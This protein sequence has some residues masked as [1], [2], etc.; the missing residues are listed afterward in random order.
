MV[1]NERAYYLHLTLR[2][3]NAARKSTS[4]EARKRHEELAIAY[5]IRC[6]L[7]ASRNIPI[8]EPAARAI[9]KDEWT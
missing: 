4:A 7:G 3:Q 1:S 8:E 6:L 2:E 5:E 9:F